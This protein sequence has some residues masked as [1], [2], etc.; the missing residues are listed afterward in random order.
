MWKGL[1]IAVLGV[2]G[3]FAFVY[4]TVI[5]CVV[6]LP[7][8]IC[9]SGGYSS[10]YLVDISLLGCAPQIF[11]WLSYSVPGVLNFAVFSL[12]TGMALISFAF[13]VS[14]DPGRYKTP[15]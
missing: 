10:C 3:I 5:F 2:L 8:S 1:N 9:A 7:L 13:C 12:N 11:P 14:V 15:L 6:W 4:T